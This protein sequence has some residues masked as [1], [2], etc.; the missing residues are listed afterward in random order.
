MANEENESYSI[1]QADWR[2]AQY[3]REEWL[4]GM[5]G[6]LL[7]EYGIADPP[8]IRVSCGWG[9]A[10]PGGRVDCVR[11]VCYSEDS[12][13][14]KTREIFI[15]PMLAEPLAVA[16]A[17]AHELV[18]ALVGFGAGHG[19]TFAE[20]GHTVGL[21]GAPEQMI[22][23]SELTDKI[24]EWITGMPEYPHAVLAPPPP[25]PPPPAPT[26]P[27][28]TRLLKGMCPSCE[29]VIRVT[30]KWASR[31]MPTCYCGGLIALVGPQPAKEE[32][33]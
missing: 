23:G 15:S 19:P 12:S 25:E 28:P 32:Q 1:S 9:G 16:Q 14:D 24:M 10:A 11:G 26:P 17:L 8:A 20:F 5:A 7:D 18:H 27:Q 29:Y 6:R 4:N 30:L 33:S 13:A 21:A 22:P 3:T 31:G 2:A